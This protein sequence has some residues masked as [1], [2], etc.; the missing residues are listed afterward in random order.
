VRGAEQQ[1][2]GLGMSLQELRTVAEM[3]A[4][5]KAVRNRVQQWKASPKPKL[6][7]V[8]E[9]VE[10]ESAAPLNIKSERPGW[11]P[12]ILEGVT[13]IKCPPISLIVEVVCKRYGVTKLE[14]MSARK[15]FK[16]AR[17]RQIAMVIARDMTLRP[18]TVI[19]EQIGGRDHSTV[20]HAFDK[21]TKLRATD[22]A[23]DAEIRDIES[24]I[25]ARMQ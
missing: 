21:F 5:Y 24:A 10:R 20:I 19:G 22:R 12:T 23:L 7:R 15:H 18:T 1:Q 13:Q 14:M 16:V 11:V 9:S 3:R 25:E 2:E 6:V 4:H 17:A 8:V